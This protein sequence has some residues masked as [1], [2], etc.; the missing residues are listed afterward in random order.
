MNQTTIVSFQPT[1]WAFPS[2]NQGGR[3]PGFCRQY[4]FNHRG[5]SHH[6]QHKKIRKEKAASFQPTG[7]DL[8]SPTIKAGI[9]PHRL[10]CFVST[11]EE[12]SPLPNTR[13]CCTAGLF[14]PTG[15]GSTIRKPRT[16]CF[17]SDGSL[18]S[19][20]GMSRPTPNKGCT[21]TMP[22]TLTC[23]NQRGWDQPSPTEHTDS[24]LD[25]FMFQPTGTGSTTPHLGCCA[26]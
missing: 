4:G 8:P 23:F 9:G 25:D 22:W 13:I 20:I 2:P 11:N 1:R 10:D 12:G 18:V 15:M 7:R 3:R 19:T 24:S 26:I 17:A 14:Q 5:G 21:W 16:G 6:P